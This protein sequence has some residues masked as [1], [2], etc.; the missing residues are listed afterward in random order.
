MGHAMLLI[1]EENKIF[2]IYLRIA[3]TYFLYD[4]LNAVKDENK[5]EVRAKQ[6]TFSSKSFQWPL[7]TN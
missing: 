1:D 4:I 2:L 5:Q 6:Y 3:K 7:G